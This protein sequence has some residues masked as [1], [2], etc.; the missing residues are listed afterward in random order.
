MKVLPL[1]AAITSVLQAED[2]LLKGPGLEID[3]IS[4]NRSITPGQSM[5]VGLHI[6]HLPGFH[7]YWKSPGMVGMA[8]SINWTLPEGFSASEIQWPSPE[9]TFMGEYPCHGYERDVTLLVTIT[10]PKV[11]A[12]EQVTFQ[13]E[14][15]W[16]CC[17]KGCFPGN[18]TFALTLPVTEESLP[19]STAKK[20]IEKAK[21][22]LP[23]TSHGIKATL[24][25]A[26]D[27]P[28]IEIHFSSDNPLT[29]DDLY[30]FSGDGQ[31]SSDQKQEFI[32]HE[33]GSLV[34]KIARSKFS[35]EQKNS[36]PGILK[37]GSKSLT[38]DAK[39]KI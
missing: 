33:D 9:N 30:F 20:Q 10:T 32:L 15:M 16:M 1:L 21:W 17:A 25:S 8:T 31:I 24:L 11:I 27:A 35:P 2:P 36:L 6:D 14:T 5:T 12:T 13:A 26:I 34:L 23:A 3:L 37:I 18:Q 22:Q 29:K 19:D 28:I 39:P 38:I 4:E 7:T